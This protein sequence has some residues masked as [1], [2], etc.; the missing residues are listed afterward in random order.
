MRRFLDFMLSFGAFPGETGS[1]RARRRIIVAALWLATLITI[2]TVLSDLEAGFLWIAAANAVVIVLAPTLL[3]ILNRFPNRFALI[4]NVM[5]GAAYLLG[6]LEPTLFGGLVESGV[7]ALF[8]LIIVVGALVALGIRAATWWFGAFVLSV[9]YSVL[10]PN[11]VDPIYIVED[12]TF[13]V[14]FNLI[15]TGS[16]VFAVMIYFVRQRNRFQ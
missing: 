1:Q 6:S 13:D 10:I 12:P 15:A 11:W 5:F 16:V 3:L 2:P 7:S 14:A 9:I 8:P 4:V